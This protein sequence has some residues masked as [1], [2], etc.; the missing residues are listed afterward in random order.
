MKIFSTAPEGNEMAEIANARYFNLAIRQIEDNIEWL[1]TANKPT[2]AV[3]A[4]IDILLMLS[5][6]FKV[7]ANLS[8]EKNKVQEWKVIFN[9]WFE[10]CGSK[11]PAKYRD[12]IK[13]NG[14]ELFKE[15]QQYGH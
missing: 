1:K 10:R 4:H 9:D 2:Q 7:D 14:D 15:L 3:L 12:G 8:I 5:R 6:K 11:I 13:A